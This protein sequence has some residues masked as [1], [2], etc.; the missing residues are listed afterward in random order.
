M[1]DEALTTE[2]ILSRDLSSLTDEEFS[3]YYKSTTGRNA[4]QPTPASRGDT[5]NLEIWGSVLGGIGAGA[6]AGTMGAGPVA[7][8]KSCSS[9]L[10][11]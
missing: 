11:F 4:F 9:C 10:K 6:L 8:C 1:A 7:S 3:S 2:D 5:D